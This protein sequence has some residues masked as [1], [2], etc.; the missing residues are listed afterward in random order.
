MKTLEPAPRVPHDAT[1]FDVG[2]GPS[3]ITLGF[4]GLSDYIYQKEPQ[5]RIGSYLG[6]HVFLRPP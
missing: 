5:N 1:L 6:H 4:W 3:S 2:V